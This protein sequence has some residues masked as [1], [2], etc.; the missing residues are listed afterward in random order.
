M[1]IA[2]LLTQ[3]H[4][5]I[6]ALIEESSHGSGSALAKLRRRLSGHIQIEERLL[7]PALEPLLPMPIRVM[8]A[9]HREIERLLAEAVVGS[10]PGL[11]PLESLL[12]D[13]NMKEERIIYPACEGPAFEGKDREVESALAAARAG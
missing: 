9:E 7:F 6:D 3:D 13:H 5:E 11:G 10:T 8:I 2:E 12:A 1:K 4:R